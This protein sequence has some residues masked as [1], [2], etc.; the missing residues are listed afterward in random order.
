MHLPGRPLGRDLGNA[1]YATVPVLSWPQIHASGFR[2][3]PTYVLGTPYP[4]DSQDLARCLKI[5]QIWSFSV[6]PNPL[7]RTC[8][9]D[10]GT[11]HGTVAASSPLPP[12]QGRALELDL[13]TFKSQLYHTLSGQGP[14]LYVSSP[15]FL[16]QLVRWFKDTTDH[17][18]E[19]LSRC[20]AYSKCTAKGS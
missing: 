10:M 20:L 3:T 1:Y 16:H 13:P 5:I 2:P 19:M 17:E 6:P 15:Q 7:K 8:F 12:R 14:S 9:K 4:Q 11:S 18:F